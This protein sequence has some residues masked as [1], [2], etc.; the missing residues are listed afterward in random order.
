MAFNGLQ[1][2]GM[3]IV[4]HSMVEM[5][6][7]TGCV[8]AVHGLHESVHIQTQ[9]LCQ[10]G[11]RI[12][13]FTRKYWGHEAPD[14]FGVDDGVGNLTRLLRHQTPPNRIAFGPKIFAF[15]IKALGILIHY[16]TQ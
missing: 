11:Q 7:T 14:R 3:A 9:F 8:V 10:F 1:V 13:L 16:H 6:D 2:F 4:Q 15:I 5:T 12:G